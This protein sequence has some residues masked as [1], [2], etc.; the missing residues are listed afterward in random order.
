MAS[1][2]FVFNLRDVVRGPVGLEGDEGR[3]GD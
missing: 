2:F 1:S 3:V